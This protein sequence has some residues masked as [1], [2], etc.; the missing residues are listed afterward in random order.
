MGHHPITELLLDALQQS[1]WRDVCQ[2]TWAHLGL[3]VT[4][5]S[6][7]TGS[8]PHPEFVWTCVNELL[9]PYLLFEVQEIYR[10]EQ[11][12]LFWYCKVYTWK[13]QQILE[14]LTILQLTKIINIAQQSSD[15]FQG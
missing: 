13:Y 9:Y 4:R 10:M 5:S 3:I 11:K 1:E 6:V 15:F 2:F 7:F 14:Y 12:Y 8:H